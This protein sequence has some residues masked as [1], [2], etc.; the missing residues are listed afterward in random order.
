MASRYDL[1]KG[2][3]DID[4]WGI[5]EDLKV[6]E[7]VI[8]NERRVKDTIERKKEEARN[9]PAPEPPEDRVINR[10]F[11]VGPRNFDV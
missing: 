11:N 9:R 2:D 3:Q 1:A 8:A 4:L 6:Q 7:D 10:K 5:Q